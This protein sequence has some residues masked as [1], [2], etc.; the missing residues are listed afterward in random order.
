MAEFTQIAVADVPMGAEEVRQQ[1]CVLT[2]EVQSLL[3]AVVL[4]RGKHNDLVDEVSDAF[5]VVE[6]SFKSEEVRW[7]QCNS[8]L[9]FIQ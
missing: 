6:A 8:D 5:T 7:G 2:A 9:Q 3:G 1:V 4:L